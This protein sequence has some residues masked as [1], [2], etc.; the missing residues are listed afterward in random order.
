[1]LKNLAEE[2]LKLARA[3]VRF[4]SALCPLYVRF[5]SLSAVL[6]PFNVRFFRLVLCFGT[7][8]TDVKWM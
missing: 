3:I 8:D 5:T 4:M 7:E 2:L 1:M 6:P